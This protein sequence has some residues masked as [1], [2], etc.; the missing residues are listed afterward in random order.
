MQRSSMGAGRLPLLAAMAAVSS[1]RGYGY[2][3]APARLSHEAGDPVSAPISRQQ[4]E[5]EDP[6]QAAVRRAVL[7]QDRHKQLAK[8][9]A[10]KKKRR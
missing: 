4:Y 8:K 7:R 6:A 1:R 3:N 10:E 5:P 9:L 2:A